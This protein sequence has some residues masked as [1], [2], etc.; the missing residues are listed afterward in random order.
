MGGETD[1]SG[2]GVGD[3]ADFKFVVPLLVVDPKDLCEGVG[4]NN[5]VVPYNEFDR[6]GFN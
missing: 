6:N 5:N 3:D 4:L 1:G 2:V